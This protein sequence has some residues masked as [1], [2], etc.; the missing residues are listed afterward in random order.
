LGL[1]AEKEF[2]KR[3]HE[4]DEGLFGRALLLRAEGRI[5]SQ[6]IENRQARTPDALDRPSRAQFQF[7]KIAC[8]KSSCDPAFEIAGAGLACRYRGADSPE[9]VVLAVEMDVEPV[10]LVGDPSF[11]HRERARI[12]ARD[13]WIGGYLVGDRVR[14]RKFPSLRKP[15]CRAGNEGAGEGARRLGEP[16]TSLP[17]PLLLRRNFPTAAPLPS[18]PT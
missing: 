10:G 2:L 18:R 9:P 14:H 16:P 11:E 3:S 13:I 15:T 12:P 1:D 6:L 17:A 5:A 4:Q 8:P 7:F